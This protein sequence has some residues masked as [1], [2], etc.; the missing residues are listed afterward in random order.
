MFRHANYYE[1]NDT[2][3]RFYGGKGKREEYGD[4]FDVQGGWD[5]EETEDNVENCQWFESFSKLIRKGT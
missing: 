4:I 3:R 2:P 1:N 5:C